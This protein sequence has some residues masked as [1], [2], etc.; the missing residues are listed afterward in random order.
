[1]TTTQFVMHVVVFPRVIS[2]VDVSA[3][4]EKP[5][6]GFPVV[7]EVSGDWLSAGGFPKDQ[8]HLHYLL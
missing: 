2:A 3:A 1:M 4:V 8:T 7:G 6:E 5:V